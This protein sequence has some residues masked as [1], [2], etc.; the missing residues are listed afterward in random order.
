MVD[1]AIAE[2]RRSERQTLRLR[3]VWLIAVY[4]VVVGLAV[5]ILVLI[6]TM[7]GSSTYAEDFRAPIYD[8][9]RVLAHG[10]NPYPTSAHDFTT[11]PSV[12]VPP[13]VL[14]AIVPLA[15]LPEWPAVT[16]WL[17]LL[18]G[19]AVLIPV[20]LQVKG[21]RC[22]ILWFTCP[23]VI[24]G[25][26]HG[27]AILL[28][29]LSVAVA[30]RWRDRPG[31]VATA[32]T[33]A[34]VL[35]YWPFLFVCWLIFT[36]RVRAAVFVTVATPL[37]VLG[38]WAAIGFRGISSYPSM[39]GEMTRTLADH[40]AF[41]I[42]ALMNMGVG[43][44]AASAVGVVLATVAILVGR[45]RGHWGAFFWTAFGALLATATGWFHYL[46]V[47]AVTVG[48]RSPR[49]DRAWLYLPA[50]W[51]AVDAYFVGGR[52]ATAIVSVALTLLLGLYAG[53]S[54]TRERGWKPPGAG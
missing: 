9:A 21:T 47:I 34:A 46:S 49:Y 31:I 35:K 37:V 32:L 44:S 43:Y 22:W 12:V 42:S 39:L 11:F 25:A 19:A 6:A 15:L 41:A 2:P 48:A 3:L 4:L 38:S 30:W 26:F 23:A 1:G 13:V 40:G 33:I 5:E 50:L 16:L 54:A 20:V 27:N 45:R 53:R 29:A 7:G 51:L 17:S 28:V 8:A 14:F 24:I 52:A 18:V 36:R 10:G